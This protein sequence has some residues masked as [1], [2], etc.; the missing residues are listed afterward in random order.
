MKIIDLFEES[1]L[2]EKGDGNFLVECPS[3]GSDNS[4]YGGMV[5]NVERNI[6][7]CF[8]SKTWFTLKE[9]YALKKGIINCTEGRRKQ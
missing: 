2:K 4:D 6:S 7:Y 1:E 3:C 5:L 9:T 8:G